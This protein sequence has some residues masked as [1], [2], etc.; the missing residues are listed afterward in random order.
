MDWKDN[1]VNKYESFA[2][3]VL[4]FFMLS[5]ALKLPVEDYLYTNLVDYISRWKTESGCHLLKHLSRCQQQLFYADTGNKTQRKSRYDKDRL[6]I[7][8]ADAIGILIGWI[9]EEHRTECFE[10]ASTIVTK[11]LK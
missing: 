11:E 8:L 7:N 4:H 9:P 3:S 2:A 6:T 5:E 10:I 1:S